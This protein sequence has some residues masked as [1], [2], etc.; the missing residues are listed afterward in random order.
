M[1]GRVSK[2]LL[3]FFNS[4]FWPALLS[5]F[6]APGMGQISNRDYGKGVLLLFASLIPLITFYNVLQDRLALLLPGAPEAWA[7]DPQALRVALTK[8]VAQNPG[9]FVTFYALIITVWVY[10]V[11]DAFMMGRRKRKN[12]ALKNEQDL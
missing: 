3:R 10:G 11:V 7:K 4:P 2:R 5:A 8:I 12:R 9:L 6:V 1:A